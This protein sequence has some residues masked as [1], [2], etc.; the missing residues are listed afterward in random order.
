[1]EYILENYIELSKNGLPNNQNPMAKF[2]RSELPYQFKEAIPDSRKYDIKGSPGTSHWAK[3][4]WIGILNRNI[5]SSFQMGYYVAYIFKEDM[6]GFYLSLIFGVGNFRSYD[7]KLLSKTSHDIRRIISD[8][9]PKIK[10]HS[11]IK[12]NNITPIASQYEK[13]DIYSIEYSKDNLPSESELMDDLIGLLGIYDFIQENNFM[14][15]IIDN[16]EN[17]NKS[18]N[19]DKD[20]DFPQKSDDSDIKDT[21]FDTE[22]TKHK[23]NIKNVENNKRNIELESLERKY[24]DITIDNLNTFYEPVLELFKDGNIHRNVEIFDGIAKIL[25]NSDR[26]HEKIKE[27]VLFSIKEFL[28][29]GC[30]EKSGLES[31]HITEDGIKLLEKDIDLLNSHVL[32]K[33][34]PK[35]REKYFTNNNFKSRTQSESNND[36]SNVIISENPELDEKSGSDVI[37]DDKI[38]IYE[39]ESK[40]NKYYNFKK[41]SNKF[42]T[43]RELLSEEN[44]EKLEDAQYLEEDEFNNIIDNIISTHK[45]V[46]K[47]IIE[48]NN[49]DFTKLTILEKMFLFS[50]SFVKT[51]YKNGGNDLGYYRFNEIYIEKRE[52]MDYKKIR[53]IIHELSHFLFSELLEQVMSEILD[54]DK[55]DILEAYIFY[56]LTNV[57]DFYL[58][59]EYCACTVEGRFVPMGHQD[60]TSFINSLNRKTFS[61]DDDIST[62]GNTFAGYIMTIMESFIDEDLIDDIRNEA[63][64]IDY[65]DKKHIKYETDESVEWNEFREIIYMMLDCKANKKNNIEFSETVFEYSRKI[66][67]NNA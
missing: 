37:R 19:S 20:K 35:Y 52:T 17:L 53:T 9:F 58:M 48:K 11:P 23:I 31:Y 25:P 27:Y 47:K 3:I 66:E 2:I 41:H 50:K 36:N 63:S 62:Y 16:S 28:D 64:N 15:L 60:Y 14:E 30:L 18:R 49:I 10:N 8:S 39:I 45:K 13:G 6:S 21:G 29:A 34:C 7:S 61:N 22:S 12:L 56:T 1:M 5:S 38:N 32:K 65:P 4:P 54:T 46:L 24:P 40:P 44:I 55:T 42:K 67:E 59:D 43:L 26:Y 51:H 57:N 33:Y